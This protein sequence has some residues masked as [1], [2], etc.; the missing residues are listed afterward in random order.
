M[1]KLGSNKTA[2]AATIA[3]A[4][5]IIVLALASLPAIHAEPDA[6]ALYSDNCASCHGR[7]FG[8]PRLAQ[9]MELSRQQ[10]EALDERFAAT[11]KNGDEASDMPAFGETLDDRQI[12]ALV[13]LVRE[14]LNDQALDERDFDSDGGVFTTDLHSFTL[15]TLASAGGTFWSMAF[16]GD[17]GV[18]ITEQSG[19]LYRW[20]GEGE[21][22][23][24]IAGVPKVRSRGQGGMLDVLPHPEHSKNGWLYLAYSDPLSGMTSVVR[25]RIRKGEWTDEETIFRTD[26][27]YDTGTSYHYGT[28][29]VFRDGYLYFGIGDRGRQGQSQQLARPNGKIH[30]V[31]D[32]GRIPKDNPF[33]GKKGAMASIWTWGNRNPQGL[34]LGPDN[35]LWSAEHG[36]RGGD[37]I[38]LIRR[39]LNYGW[40]ILSHGINYSGTPFAEGTEREGYASPAWH[41]TPSI[42]PS[43]LDYYEGEAFGQWQ[44]SLLVASLGRQQLHRLEIKGETVVADELIMKGQG[45]I[46]DVRCGPDGLIYLLMETHLGSRLQVMEPLAQAASEDPETG[47]AKQKARPETP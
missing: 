32:D 39:G 34:T 18:L 12:R 7:S 21:E 37:E 38:N 36:P 3:A 5:A 31:H 42:A 10:A 19:R 13:V 29:M 1:A 23:E 14:H 8:S 6:D 27:K 20:R 25:G 44:G 26:E 4:L 16:A 45:R 28:R 9:W 24:R 43:N 11:I 33:I 46:R 2:L 15:R 47:G 22:L 35:E 30:R 17:D 41:W 40:P